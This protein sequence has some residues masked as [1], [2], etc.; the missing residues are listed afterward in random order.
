MRKL[1]KI[2]GIRVRITVIAVVRTALGKGCVGQRA[3]LIILKI[4]LIKYLKNI[5]N[6]CESET[7]IDKIKAVLDAEFNKI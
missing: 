4:L 1:L 7:V 6:L 5:Y 2:R 3:R